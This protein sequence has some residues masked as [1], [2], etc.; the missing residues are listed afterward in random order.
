M[1][2]TVFPN[3]YNELKKNL[4]KELKEYLKDLKIESTQVDDELFQEYWDRTGG[5]EDELRDA[6]KDLREATEDVRDG[7]DELSENNEDIND[8]TSDIFDSYLEQT[9]NTLKSY[10]IDVELTE[11]NFESKLDEVIDASPVPAMKDALKD[12]KKQ[13]QDLKEYKDGLKDYTDG[14]DELYDGLDDMSDGVKDL[15]EAVD[16]AL[17]EFDFDGMRERD[18]FNNIYFAVLDRTRE[19]YNFNEFSRNFSDF[20]RDE[21]Q[22][23]TERALNELKA[24]E[25][26]LDAARGCIFGG[27][28]GDALGSPVEFLSEEE[29]YRKY[30]SKGITSYEKDRRTGKALISDDTQMTLFTAN[31]L[32]I[33]NTRGGYARHKSFAT[34]LCGNSIFGL[35][36][37]AG[38]FL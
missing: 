27:A 2:L 37:N 10:G 11:S 14:V 25:I 26:H 29:I 13:L 15:D 9:T 5:V 31:G 28:V 33:G 36:Y 23:E 4:Y 19:Q 7:L 24:A 20:Y 35:A 30:G 18:M 6:V 17:K 38:V 32:M 3:L 1:L 22:A 12:T 34:L 8:A 16:D 21:D